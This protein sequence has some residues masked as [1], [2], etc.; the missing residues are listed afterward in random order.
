MNTIKVEK[1]VLLTPIKTLFPNELVR[2]PNNT[3]TPRQ[4]KQ[5]V[6]SLPVPSI[7]CFK[8]FS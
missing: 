5:L 4:A 3:Q 8:H 1:F 2:G 7:I 6:S